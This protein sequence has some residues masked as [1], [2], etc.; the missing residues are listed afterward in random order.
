MKGN[1]FWVSAA[2][3][4]LDHYSKWLAL[5]HLDSGPSIELVPGYLRLSLVQNTG[6]AFGLLNNFD[7]AWKPFALAGLA[8]VA[9]VFILF[10]A[11]RTPADR[12]LMHTA[13]AVTLGGI[14]GNFI[15][16]ITRGSVVDFIEFHVHDRFYWPTF[17]VADSAITVGLA[18]LLL[19][20]FRRPVSEST[21]SS[22]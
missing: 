8:V 6:V 11:A 19:D 16:R 15:D 1:V 14:A 5:R 13:L 4:I 9:I 2:I 18:I 22:A 7:A 17:N 10:Y 21:G 20:T 12:R 3:L